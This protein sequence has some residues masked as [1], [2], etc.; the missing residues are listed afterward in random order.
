MDNKYMKRWPTSLVNQE[1]WFKM[2]TY[3]ESIKLARLKDYVANVW[4][5]G[6]PRTLDMGV[7][8]DAAF[9]ES[10]LTKRIRI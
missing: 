4:E 6:H 7:K 5:N 2:V 8:I 9:G 3:F 1:M 10:G